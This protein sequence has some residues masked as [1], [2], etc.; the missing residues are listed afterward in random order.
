MTTPQQVK[1]AL[2]LALS[3]SEGLGS[4]SQVEAQEIFEIL[5]EIN[6]NISKSTTPE[7]TQKET[8][9][10]KVLKHPVDALLKKGKVEL[11][12]R[13]YLQLLVIYDELTTTMRVKFLSA[14]QNQH[15]TWLP[16]EYQGDK[17]AALFLTGGGW[18]VSPVKHTG[19]D[20]LQGEWEGFDLLD[21]LAANRP[22]LDL[23][24]Y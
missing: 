4:L 12:E 24:D 11:S 1:Q 19:E 23:D 8:T 3:L 13:R 7:P 10:K 15:V 9:V 17:S 18:S 16:L 14:K 21:Q 20:E 2:E 6:K 5:G 22:E